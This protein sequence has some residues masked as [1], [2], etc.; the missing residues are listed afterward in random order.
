MHV[1]ASKVVLVDCPITKLHLLHSG[2]LLRHRK[3]HV[4]RG[5]RLHGAQLLLLLLRH[6][7][8]HHLRLMLRLHGRWASAKLLSSKGWWL[9]LWLRKWRLQV[10][11]EAGL[12]LHGLSVDVPRVHRWRRMSRVGIHL[13]PS[14]W[15]WRRVAG[16]CCGL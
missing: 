14:L 10:G 9:H 5:L 15:R 1:E 8:L 2:L 7:L 4:G 12:L 3:L 16:N 11:L 13:W 6:E